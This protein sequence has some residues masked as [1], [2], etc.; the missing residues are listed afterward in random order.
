LDPEGRG[1]S[2]AQEKRLTDFARTSMEE[3]P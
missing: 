1:H 3:S 2:T